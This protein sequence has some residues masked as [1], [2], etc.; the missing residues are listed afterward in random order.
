MKKSLL[1]RFIAKYSL[2]GAVEAVSWVSDGTSINVKF[3][4][5]DKT[6]I[7]DITLI[8]RLPA[9]EYHIYQ[10][11]KL[12]SL[13]AV[14]GDDIDIVS[15]R[16]NGNG[17]PHSLTIRPASYVGKPLTVEFVLAVA[18]AI[19]KP[20]TLTKTPPV[21]YSFAL[22]AIFATTFMKAK[23]SL[24]DVESFA[25]IGDGQNVE[26][27]VGYDAKQATTKVS[28]PISAISP[29]Q[30]PPRFFSTKYLTA[31]IQANKD[32]QSGIVFLSN[33]NNGIL[34]FVFQT[35]GFASQYYLFGQPK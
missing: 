6:L 24:A 13:L 18:A 17:V 7:G 2:G 28:I 22:D 19:G 32:A 30:H 15:N 5:D 14:F 25:L 3:A 8:E 16:K 20:P 4:T 9:G 11:D 1:E 26:L 31:I 10:T 12:R 27:V 33:V 29:V 21:D 23:N 35:E 34:T